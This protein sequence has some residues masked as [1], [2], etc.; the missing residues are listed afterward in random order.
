MKTETGPPCST[1]VERSTN[2]VNTVKESSTII[3]INACGT[4]EA[5]F[6][7]RYWTENFSKETP[8]SA[9]WGSI[10]RRLRCISGLTMH[11]LSVTNWIVHTK[12]KLA[13]CNATVPDYWPWLDLT[14]ANSHFSEPDRDGKI[15][16]KITLEEKRQYVT[17][18]FQQ[19]SLNYSAASKTSSPRN[20]LY[21]L[22]HKPLSKC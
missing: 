4:V 16:R 17:R 18:P 3:S 15:V 21:R 22:C 13:G 2:T 9:P 8:K 7:G 11:N 1:K 19:K 5:E 12:V 14:I 6:L 10:L 20:W